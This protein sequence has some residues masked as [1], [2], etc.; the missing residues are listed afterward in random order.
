MDLFTE[1]ANNYLKL[2]KSPPAKDKKEEDAESA[3][4]SKDAQ[5]MGLTK[6]VEAA[7]N[8]A[9]KLATKP[10]DFKNAPFIGAQYKMNTAY[11]NLMKSIAG[12]IT[13]LSNS[14][15]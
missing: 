7:V 12:K 14:I 1:K 9:S 15:R 6:D 10:G 11:G 3:V 2:V 5:K 13:K 4:S 8:I